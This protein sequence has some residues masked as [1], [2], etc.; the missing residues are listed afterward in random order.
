[1][2]QL[3][4]QESI[5]AFK[6]M[7][8]GLNY[9]KSVSGQLLKVDDNECDQIESVIFYAYICGHICYSG[10][11]RLENWNYASLVNWENCGWKRFSIFIFKEKKLQLLLIMHT[12]ECLEK[13]LDTFQIH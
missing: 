11:I 3:Q 9:G 4:Q 13:C 1:M 8:F 6:S 2:L 12:P 10:F 7:P 5:L